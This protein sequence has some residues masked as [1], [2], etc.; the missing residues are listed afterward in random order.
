MLNF[1]TGKRIRKALPKGP[2]TT[3]DTALRRDATEGEHTRRRHQR[4]PRP[5]DT[6]LGTLG[7]DIMGLTIYSKMGYHIKL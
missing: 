6:G 2:P 5:G 4:G 3:H 7:L 1:A